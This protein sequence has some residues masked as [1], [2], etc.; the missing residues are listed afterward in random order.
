MDKVLASAREAVRDIPD[1]ATIA[2]GGF[3][4][5]GIPELAIAALAERFVAE[6]GP[7]GLTFVSTTAASTTSASAS[8]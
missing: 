3:G 6:G 8:C 2:A 4:L 7:K 5:C 1:G